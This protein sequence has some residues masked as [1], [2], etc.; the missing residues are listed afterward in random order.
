MEPLTENVEDFNWYEDAAEIDLEEFEPVEKELDQFNFLFTSLNRILYYL[1]LI[2]GFLYIDRYLFGY[3]EMT[4]FGM[5]VNEILLNLFVFSGSFNLIYFIISILFTGFTKI[6]IKVLEIRFK[7]VVRWISITIW[8]I[9]LLYFSKHQM[10][11]FGDYYP[12]INSFILSGIL[13]GITFS[14]L[15]FGIEM[16]YE[17]FVTNSLASKVQEVDRREKIISAMKNYRYEISDSSTDETGGCNCTELFFGNDSE[18]DSNINVSHINLNR[19]ENDQIGALYFKKPELLSLHDAKTLAKD[20]FTKA[21]EK[22][23]M[24]FQE[25]SEIFPNTQIAIQAFSYFDV[26]NDQ[27]IS[28]KEF[29]DALINFYISRVNLEKGFD[30]AKGF[31]QIVNNIASIVTLLFLALAYLVL[32]GI[33]LKDLLALALSSA[34][35][36]NF[37]M[38]G[39]ATDI[40]FNITILL[41]HPFDIG[42]DVIIEDENYTV[43]K[44]GITSTSFLAKNGGKVKFMNRDLWTKTLINMTR[45]PEKVL[46][47]TFKLQPDIDPEKFRIFKTRIHKYLKVRNFDFYEAFSLE[48]SSEQATDISLLDCALVLKCRSYKTKAKKFGLRAEINKFLINLLEELEISTK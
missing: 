21:T 2:S 22:D 15:S 10:D 41:S 18:N 17:S 7:T 20:I 13:T 16:F 8:F 24:N 46:F 12:I 23:E 27:T 38:S 40:Y 32:F 1:T 25:F 14:L 11:T 37:A 19:L 30:I 33:P 36:L 47:F 28:K 6:G 5:D 29:K 9:I 31:V 35:V 4:L 45:A 26:N 42:D 34:L 3:N 43:F 48:A 44:I 39:L